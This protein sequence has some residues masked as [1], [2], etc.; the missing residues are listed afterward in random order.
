MQ[1]E[2]PTITRG[3]LFDFFFHPPSLSL[4]EN[5]CKTLDYAHMRLRV[6]SNVK[7]L[8]NKGHKG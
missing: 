4:T 8:I 1:E 5:A 3:L 7:K 6:P 2:K